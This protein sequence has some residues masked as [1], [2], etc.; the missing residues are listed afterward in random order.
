[1]LEPTQAMPIVLLPSGG[2]LP[3]TD[4]AGEFAFPNIYDG[5]YQIR[6]GRLPRGF[7]V[8]DIREGARTIY[9]N[10]TIVVGAEPPQPIEIVLARGEARVQGSVFDAAGSPVAGAE[11]VL[12]PEPPN[13]ENPMLYAG[14][15]S[16]VD[17]AFTMR[18]LAPGRHRAYAFPFSTGSAEMN[19]A[20]LLKYVQ[21]GQPVRADLSGTASV[22]LRLVPESLGR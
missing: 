6:L 3:R 2:G 10:A 12:V 22:S 14:S 19:G 13:S 17:G 9:G 20:W 15:R 18:G 4:A 11:V 8:A 21:F 16:G 7:Y 5:P 1:M